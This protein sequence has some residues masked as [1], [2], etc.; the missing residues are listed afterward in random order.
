MSEEENRENVAGEAAEEKKVQEKKRIQFF[1]IKTTKGQE[2]NVS[3]LIE[4]RA[5]TRKIE[6][7]SIVAPP[8]PKGFLILETPRASTIDPLTRDIRHVKG[9]IKGTIS[10]DDVEH[11]V[12]PRPTVE[13]LSP[14]IEVEVIAG[15]LKGSKGKVLQVNKSRNEVVLL[16]YEATYP[17]KV[18]IPGEQVKPVSQG[19]SYE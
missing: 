8:R 11:L 18:T 19:G 3:L 6:L 15:P 17:L 7:Y 16:I 5:K 1:S 10:M 4:N 12:K 9:R 2:L 13:F 14:G